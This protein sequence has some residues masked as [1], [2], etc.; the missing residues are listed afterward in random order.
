MPTLFQ[1]KYGGAYLCQ[2]LKPTQYETLEPPVDRKKMLDDTTMSAEGA[3]IVLQGK[4]LCPCCRKREPT[5]VAYL[6]QVCPECYHR[7][8]LDRRFWQ[9]PY[10]WIINQRQKE[11]ENETT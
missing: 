11:P 3:V 9:N 6:T 2:I 7:A 10:E 4:K 1:Y 8:R 5:E